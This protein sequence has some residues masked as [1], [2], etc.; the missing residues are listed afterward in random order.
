LGWRP[1]HYAKAKANQFIS[2]V[3]GALEKAGWK[4]Q[5]QDS[6][7]GLQVMTA[8]QTSPP[9]AV[10][11]IWVAADDGLVLSWAE[12]VPERA[13]SGQVLTVIRAPRAATPSPG[14]ARARSSGLGHHLR[15][16]RRLGHAQPHEE[17]AAQAAVIPQPLAQGG[18]RA[19]LRQGQ[20]GK[21]AAG[22]GGWRALDGG[23]R[24]VLGW[25]WHDG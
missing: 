5:S 11:G 24:C 12:M 14:P 13:P 20:L 23:G 22:R 2:K 8:L 18:L 1:P 7:Q 16:R 4:V 17:R 19:R 25:Q 3:Q 10:L 6:G 21:A 15:A 9:R